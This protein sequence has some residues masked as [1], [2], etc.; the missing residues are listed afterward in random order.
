MP[1]STPRVLIVS[2]GLEIGGIERSLLGLLG[3]LDYRRCRVDLLLHRHDGP[4]M[5]YLPEGPRLLPEVRSYGS[6]ERPIQLLVREGN[7]GLA[8]ARL[9][10]K[11]RSFADRW[12]EGVV[13]PGYLQLQRSWRYALPLLPEVA[14]EYELAVSFMVPHYLVAR[15]V[16]A[17]VKV[18]WIHTDYTSIPVEEGPEDAMWGSL[19]R[20]VAVSDEVGNSFGKRFPRFASRVQVIENILAP[21]L[22]RRQASEFTPDEMP[23]LPGVT[24]ILSV[25]R[26]SHAKG[27]DQAV[28][29]CRR[30]LD[31]G[32]RVR[33]YAIGYGPDEPM[34]RAL[35]AEHG[36]QEDFVILGQ[37]INPYPYMAACDLY[38]QPSR[39]EGKAVTVREAQVLGKP[40]VITR[41]PTSSS[42][43]ADG[44]DGHICEMGVEGIAEGIGRLIDDP[45]YREALAAA[46][47]EGD[48]S[49]RCELEKIYR[50]LSPL[51]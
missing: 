50:L 7:A 23:S 25:G 12:K 35:I 48:Y 13:E 46:A 4:F 20:L 21:E 33:W 27:I 14:G 6:F 32:R 8:A 22:I 36:L 38:V 34:I 17:R 29:A 37:K 30:L 15:R 11:A 45:G 49:N 28:L 2:A 51:G 3:G 47:R 1:S 19:D 24:R 44:V 26:F 40:V 16:R 5:R 42:Q 41:Y 31:K 43:V 10:A 18:G 9:L 39:Y